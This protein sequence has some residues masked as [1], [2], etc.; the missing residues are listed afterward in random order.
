[1]NYRF[2]TAAVLAL[3]TVGVSAQ[4]A[5]KPATLEPA[6]SPFTY[7]VLGATPSLQLGKRKASDSEAR[8][9]AARES[10]SKSTTGASSPRDE[11][12]TVESALR[13]Q[14]NTKQ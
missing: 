3:S 7:E 5:Q 13:S 12:A 6:H 8:L 11:P 10:N 9:A 14:R 2:I 4:T 1:M